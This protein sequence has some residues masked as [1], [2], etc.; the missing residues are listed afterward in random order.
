M[1]VYFE[2]KSHSFFYST[3]LKASFFFLSFFCGV[4]KGGVNNRFRP[5]DLFY[6]SNKRYK[7]KNWKKERKSERT[8]ESSR[9]LFQNVRVRIINDDGYKIKIKENK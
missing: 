3:K 2:K 6:S 1:K 9:G 4:N 8:R 7:R 5:S